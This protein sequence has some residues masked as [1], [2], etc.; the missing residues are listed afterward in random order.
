M[1]YTS[2][3]LQSFNCQVCRTVYFKLLMVYSYTTI[4][5]KYKLVRT[6]VLMSLEHDSDGF[7]VASTSPVAANCPTYSHVSGRGGDKHCTDCCKALSKKSN[8][9]HYPS[10]SIC[11]DDEPQT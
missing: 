9:Q 3:C 4:V 5:T 11:T 1:Y 2:V 8:N 10:A 6:K 7:V